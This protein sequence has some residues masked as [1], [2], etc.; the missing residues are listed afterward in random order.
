VR[1]IKDPYRAFDAGATPGLSADG[2]L[3]ATPENVGGDPI[4]VALWSLPDGRPLGAP[5]RV[6][7]VIVD[8]QLSPDGR[9]FTVV[10]ADAGHESGWVEAWDVRTRRRVRRLSLE[11]LPAFT[12]FSPDGRRFAIGNRY[13]ESRVYETA[14]F[15]PVT[16]VLAGDAGGIISAAITRDGRTLATGSETGAV[17]LWDIPT[18]QA[19]GA[20]LPGVPSH[21]VIPAFTPDGG[22]LVAAYDTGRAYLWDIRPASLAKHA[23]DVAG[24]RLTRAEWEAFLPGRDYDPAC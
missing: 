22:H 16:P 6:D 20:P 21:A 5:L 7:H 11:R 19:L 17:Q 9:L 15:E 13:G 4:E 3:L 24:R 18:G 23:C 2:R 1:T 14:T 12:R 10:L 8:L